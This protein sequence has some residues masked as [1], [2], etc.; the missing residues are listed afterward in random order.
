MSEDSPR[1]PYPKEFRIKGGKV[2]LR[3]MASADAEAIVAFARQLPEHDLLFLRRDITQ[4][5][6]V[7]D[8]AAEI[9]SGQITTL[10]AFEGDD[11]VG[12]GTLDRGGMPWTPH[13]AELRILL[14]PALRGRGLGRLLTQEV[15]LLA[16]DGGIEKIIA[17]MTADQQAAITIFRGMGF[18]PEAML[19]DHVMGRDGKKYDLV[20]LGHDVA[21]FQARMSALGVPEALES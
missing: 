20:I 3:L 12:Y 21:R 19:R 1:R 11:L 14:A 4:P 17:Q 16:L 5:E 10:L 2:T 13:V 6:P 18:Q 15:F 8:W 9:A 7:A